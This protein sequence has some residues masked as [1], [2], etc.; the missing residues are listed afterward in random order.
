M[1]E[2]EKNVFESISEFRSD[3]QKLLLK[4]L[5]V[6]LLAIKNVKA[7]GGYIG[8]Y[9]DFPELSYKDNGLPPLSLSFNKEPLDYRNCFSSFGREPLIQEDEISSFGEL[10]NW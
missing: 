1:S 2:D 8:K 3:Y 9:H 4:A 5:R 10:V 6:G 7:S